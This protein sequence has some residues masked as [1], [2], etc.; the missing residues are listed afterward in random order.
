MVRSIGAIALLVIA[1]AATGCVA[2][3]PA[4][5]KVS[6]S[7]AAETLGKAAVPSDLNGKTV[8]LTYDT[9]SG[10]TITFSTDGRTVTY[11]AADTGR[12]TSTPVAVEP[13]E[14][15]IFLVTWTDDTGA[16]V[17]QVQD[18]RT[19]KVEGTWT[20]HDASGQAVIETR[21][22]SVHLTD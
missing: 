21:V 11:T 8:Q 10:G 17:S 13:I 2:D 1:V 12:Q 5:Q 18:Y 14:A 6:N 22:G 19:G 4:A 7:H 16:V 15:G 20:R 3:P 9:G